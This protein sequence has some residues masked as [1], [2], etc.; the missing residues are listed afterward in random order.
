MEKNKKSHLI[1]TIIILLLIVVIGSYAINK[2]NYE[3]STE[4]KITT[5]STSLEFLESNTNIIN[6][7]DA[8]PMSDEEGKNQSDTFD[9]AVSS[10][11]SKNESISYSIILEKLQVSEGKQELSDKE[12][13][14]YL[15]DYDD[16]E[17]LLKN[18]SDISK[19]YV[20]YTKTNSHNSTTKEIKDK[21]KLKVWVDEKNTNIDFSKENNMAYSFKLR[22]KTNVSET[23]TEETYTVKYNPNTGTGNM[24]N[25]TFKQGESKKLS[26][27]TF[28]KDG[29]VFKGW[30]TSNNSKDV[31]YTD[32]QEVKNL[33]NVYNGVVNLYAVWVKE[34]VTYEIKYNPNGGHEQEPLE[35]LVTDETNHW[36]LENGVYKSGNQGVSSNTSTIKSKEFTLTTNAKISFEWAASTEDANWDYLYYSIYKDG[37]TTPISGTGASTKIGGNPNITEEE[38]LTYQTVTKELEPGTY[39]LE[40]SYKKDSTGNRGL[41]TGYVKNIIIPISN[42]M[43]NSSHEAGIK[44]KLLKNEYIKD[45]YLFK[46]WSTT[47]NGK[48]KYTDEEEVTDLTEENASVINLYAVW[49]KEKYEVNLVVQNGILNGNSIKNVNHNENGVFSVVPNEGKNVGIVTCTNGQKGSYQNTKVTIKK[50]TSNTTCT[51]KIDSEITTLYND[52]TLIINESGK[53]RELNNTKHGRVLNEYEA[54]N[55]NNSYTFTTHMNQLWYEE[56]NLIKIVE[57]E[58]VTKPAYTSHWFENL[59]NM[60][61]GDF[62]NLDTSNLKNSNYMFSYAGSAVETFNLTGLKNWDTSK[63]SNMNNMFSCIGT[64]ASEIDLKDLSN[65]DTSNV[66]NMSYMFYNTGKNSKIVNLDLSG[67]N[68]SKVTN[69]SYMFSYTGYSA[70]TFNLAGL[71][72]WD[73]SK[74]TNMSY[75]FSKAGKEATSWPVNNLS[76]WNTAKVTNMSYMFQEAGRSSSTFELILDNWDTSNVTNMSYMFNS[77]GYSAQTFSLTG[78]ENWDT[79]KVIDIS[80]MFS[81]TGSNAK[82]FNLTG[83]DKWNTSNVKSMREA[84]YYTGRDATTFNIDVSNWDTSNVTNML[85]MFSGTG[86]NSKNWSIG[87]LSNWNIS[88]VTNISYMFANT[89]KNAATWSIGDLS[90]WDTSSVTTMASMFCQ[91]ATIAE[92]NSI[93]NLK[94]P[95]GANVRSF[96]GDCPKFKGNLIIQG[97]L[98]QETD[99]FK[100]VITVTYYG[101]TDPSSYANL[102]YT[103]DNGKPSVE[104]IINNINSKQNVYNKGLWS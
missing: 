22:V 44:A 23:N 47:P 57:V 11:T 25:T 42:E 86:K 30:S 80:C 102:Y 59:K 84:F 21:Y 14:V 79:S 55:N 7:T 4:N 90:N 97:T 24:G 77:T 48:V 93:G 9:F 13:K 38:N 72:N 83:F 53:N 52:G 29:Y 6:I 5:D 46:G 27:N 100:Y 49:E 43:P 45:Y 10:K 58:N 33:T 95:A 39:V 88:K 31:V 41:D 81:Q 101:V 50:V 19:D 98:K 40:F 20:L 91:A 35:L 1:L 71:E 85:S 75:M 92:F 36:T 32:E 76:K 54:M 74:V 65:W 15:T 12:V 16:N 18:V 89:G 82:T 62:T 37:S 68:T 8:M 94:I 28:T 67:W 60:E 73:T 26:K 104:S 61:Q 87:D 70:K 66:T 96:A 63:I 78:L 3:S 103:N 2:Y 51:V 64:E 34:G 17:L 99:M 69:M 56:R